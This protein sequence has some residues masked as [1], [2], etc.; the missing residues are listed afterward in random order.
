[1]EVPLY[2]ILLKQQRYS[3]VDA[4]NFKLKTF[5]WRQKILA[6][7]IQTSVNFLNLWNYC[8]CSTKPRGGGGGG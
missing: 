2:F 3:S 4:A 1:M 7:P 5:V 6:I 8:K